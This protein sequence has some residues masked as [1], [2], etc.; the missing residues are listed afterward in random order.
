MVTSTKFKKKKDKKNAAILSCFISCWRGNYNR[1]SRRQGYIREIDRTSSIFL[2]HHFELVFA[3]LILRRPNVS[4]D[5]N[6]CIIRFCPCVFGCVRVTFQRKMCE[7]KWSAP[8]RS[9]I[10][11]RCGSFNPVVLRACGVWV[12]LEDVQTGNVL[13]SRSRLLNTFGGGG[14]GGGIQSAFVF[15][16]I[17]TLVMNGD[18]SI[19]LLTYWPAFPD[20]LPS[21][22][23][24]H[25]DINIFIFGFYRIHTKP[26]VY[27]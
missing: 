17:S 25:P 19:L 24:W 23:T 22:Y 26:V 5:N 10:T 7:K 14:G 13:I 15:S 27:Q 4:Y 2:C 11:T 1:L 3:I 6:Y 16:Y 9:T 20:L 18:D 21:R 12:K 8:L